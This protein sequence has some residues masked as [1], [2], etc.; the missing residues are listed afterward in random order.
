MMKV[1]KARKQRLLGLVNNHLAYQ[2]YNTI[3]DD[4][5]KQVEQGYLKRFV[6]WMMQAIWSAYIVIT[7]HHPQLPLSS[8]FDYT[9]LAYDQVKEEEN[10]DAQ[11]SL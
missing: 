4:L 7:V 11:G 8:L 1:N 2:E 3:L 9:L 6:S 10:I 5:D